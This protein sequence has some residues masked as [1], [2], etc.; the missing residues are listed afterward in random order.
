LFSYHDSRLQLH[1]VEHEL[2][3]ALARIA[4]VP[5]VQVREVQR[6]VCVHDD[7][8]ERKARGPLAVEGCD[9]RA[10]ALGFRRDL[11]MRQRRRVDGQAV[12]ILPQPKSAMMTT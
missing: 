11:F 7:V 12:V 6:A 4:L 8:G 10:V 5:T 3:D 9:V 2:A 1:A